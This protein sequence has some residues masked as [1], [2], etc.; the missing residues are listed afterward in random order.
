MAFVGAEKISM[1]Y[2][3]LPAVVFGL[4]LSIELV[5]SRSLQNNDAHVIAYFT[6]II[7]TSIIF[8]GK[9]DML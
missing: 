4:T 1:N 7:T 2:N 9:E 5:E 3:A 8:V 6:F